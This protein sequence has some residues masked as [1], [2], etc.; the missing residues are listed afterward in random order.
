MVTTDSDLEI[1]KHQAAVAL[2]HAGLMQGYKIRYNNLYG[3]K[4]NL[5][6]KGVAD[7]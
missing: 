4:G 2:I 7:D 1:A 6:A 3:P 5:V